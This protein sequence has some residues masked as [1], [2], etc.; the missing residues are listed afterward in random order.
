MTAD[1][2]FIEALPKAELHVHLDGSLRPSTMFE[3]AR[4]RA[5]PLPGS[6][7]RAL[8]SHMVVR[9]A[10][11]LEEYLERFDLTLSV[12]QDAEALER[13]SYE[14]VL[15]HAA[16]KVRWVE[17]RFCP[18]L[19]RR[20]GL[21]LD[22]V[23]DAALRGMRRAEADVAD[24]GGLI[25]ASII[26]CGLR[27]H[28]PRTTSETAELAVAYA[29]NGVCGF[30]LAGAEAGHPV[31]DHQ[32]AVDR[33]HTGGLAITLHAGEGF[34]PASIRQALD[35]GY[36]RRIGHGTRLGEDPELLARV[37]EEQIPLEVCLTSNVQTGVVGSVTQ[38]PARDYL[39]SGVP[40]SL[41]TDN[42]LMS[43][44]TLT[45]EYMHA[46]DALGLTPTELLAIARTGFEHAFMDEGSRSRFLA[47]LDDAAERLVPQGGESR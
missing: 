8:E 3:L 2:R 31:S 10:S 47:E 1:D 14:L 43:G 6:T 7:A 18:Q 36:A 19:N 27:S 26:V 30:D 34:G 24:S 28:E 21:T 13:I 42:R 9:D 44:V 11:S 16:E 5:V 32:D 46:R 37:A 15:D 38:H 22:N 45:E 33:A 25:E 20:Q 40:I 41:G 4:E 12:M 17:I 23:L 39:G 29:N 35:L